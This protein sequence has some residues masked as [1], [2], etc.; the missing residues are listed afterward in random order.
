[1]LSI[2]LFLVAFNLLTSRFKEA[3]VLSTSLSALETENLHTFMWGVATSAYQIEGASSADGRTPSNWDVFSHTLPNRT[4]GHDT[5]DIADN[6]YNQ[7]RDD[8][9]LVKDLNVNA[10]RFSLSWDRIVS[11]PLEKSDK[12]NPAGIA[13]YNKLIDALVAA[14]ITPVVTLFHWDL[15]ES[16]EQ[17]YDGWLSERIVED[18]LFYAETCFKAFGD[19]VRLWT[20]INEP[21]TVCTSGY[22]SG[23]MAPGRCSDRNRCALGDSATEPYLA[24]HNMLLAHARVVALY[25]EKYAAWAPHGHHGTGSPHVSTP[26]GQIGMV[27]NHEWAEPFSLEMDDVAAAQRRNE[28]YIGWFADPLV[29]GRY[30]ESMR[31]KLLSRLP[32]FTERQSHLLRGSLDYFGLN[33]YSAKYVSALSPSAVAN[34]EGVRVGWTGDQETYITPVSFSGTL[35]GPQA[36]SP[37]LHVVP[38]GLYKSLLWLDSRYRSS[39]TRGADHQLSFIVTECGVDVPNEA[40][41]PFPQVLQDDFRIEFYRGY[42]AAMKSAM[43]TGVHVVG[44]FAWSL[45]DNFEWADGYTKHFGLHWVDPPRLNVSQPSSSGSSSGRDRDKHRV[46]RRYPKASARWYAR[47]I[48]QYT[49]SATY[50]PKAQYAVPSS[51]TPTNAS[52]SDSDQNGATR[53]KNT[54]VKMTTVTDPTVTSSFEDGSGSAGLGM[55]VFLLFPVLAILLLV[56]GCK[57]HLGQGSFASRALPSRAYY[58][59]I[60]SAP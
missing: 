57:A 48:A 40:S 44:F 14:N 45:M 17:E 59:S 9:H 26:R 5:G 36:D 28:W 39:K 27:L 15:P 51:S 53:S 55:G 58:E 11:R 16:I 47:F 6:S 13:H 4:N 34:E 35:I 30:P 7:W 2:F 23:V 38:A 50:R 29:F 33:Q 20:T 1:M 21:W 37:W 10:Y 42:L 46:L 12:I 49:G 41:I 19:R 25:R 3:K 8:V 56:A 18:F 22:E 60:P 52:G 43:E 24:G 32:E 54:T 31:K